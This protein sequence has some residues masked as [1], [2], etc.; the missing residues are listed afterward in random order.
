MSQPVEFF[1]KSPQAVFQVVL[2]VEV[3]AVVERHACGVHDGGVA[4]AVV[5]AEILQRRMQAEETVEPDGV[6]GGD[7]ESPTCAGV[8]WIAERHDSSQAIHAAAEHY[9]HKAR[10]GRSR[11]GVARQ[12]R[13]GKQAGGDTEHATTGEQQLQ[14]RALLAES[15]L[16]AMC[17]RLDRTLFEH[18]CYLRWNSGLAKRIVR[19]SAVLLAPA[20][21]CF[22]AGDKF[23]R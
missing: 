6:G 1:R 14:F 9:D 5:A 3:R 10:I 23:C 8:L 4:I 12:K 2:A 15:G 22:V 7:G 17:R 20:I 18:G 11:L 21:F 13:P 16:L 19:A